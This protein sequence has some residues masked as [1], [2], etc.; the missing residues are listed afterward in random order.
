MLIRLWLPGWL[1]IYAVLAVQV[2]LALVLM[3]GCVF[4]EP[5]K[6]RDFFVV[7]LAG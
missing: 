1:H 7:V 5:G 6:C 4:D 3:T 2:L